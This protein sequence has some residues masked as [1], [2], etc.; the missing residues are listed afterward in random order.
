MNYNLH[1]HTKRCGHASGEDEEY[2]LAAI[3]AG[4]KVL[5]FSDHAPFLFPDGSEQ[6]Y[7]IPTSDAEGYINSIKALREKYA[8]RIDIRI[9]F[10]LEYY[11]EHFPAMLSYAKELGA[12]YLILGQ[13]QINYGKVS[14]YR[15]T[16]SAEWFSEQVSCTLLGMRSGAFTY[17]AHPDIMMLTGAD[18]VYDSEMRKIA[19]ES[20]ELGIPLEINLLGI[21]EGRSY[22]SEKFWRIAGEEASPVT[23]GIDAHTPSAILNSEAVIRAK[24]MIEKFDL[25]YIGQAKIKKI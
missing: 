2:V 10:E 23:I 1:T 24:S 4:I 19:R 15:I 13:H 6:N 3:K 25:N 7:R 16:D 14:S 20:R 21:R 17:V 18:D 5:G 9:G 8:N 12:E 11:P 22:P